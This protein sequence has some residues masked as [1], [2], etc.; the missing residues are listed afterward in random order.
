MR[1][2]L[3]VVLD[4]V[5]PRPSLFYRLQRPVNHARGSRKVRDHFQCQLGGKGHGRGKGGYLLGVVGDGFRE[6][7]NVVVLWHGWNSL[8]LV[9]RASMPSA[10]SV[11]NV[12]SSQRR[13]PA[14]GRA[15]RPLS[16]DRRYTAAES[17][18]GQA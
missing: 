12:R 8:M 18:E 3:R 14:A 17:R 2:Q 1:R 13:H 4:L 15:S 9:E 6:Q 10:L 16:S 7:V 5:F 11:F